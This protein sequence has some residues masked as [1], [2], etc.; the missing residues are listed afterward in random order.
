MTERSRPPVSPELPPFSLP[1]LEGAVLDTGLEILAVHDARL[2]LVHW[3]LG[4]QAGSKFEPPEL[5]GLS[6][7]TAAV[8]TQGTKSRTAREI[9]ERVAA[10][11]ASLRAWSN[12]DALLLEG[13]VLAENLGAFL[14]LACDVARNAV[15]PEEEVELR[16]QNRK[17]ELAAQRS[18]ADFLAQEKTAELVFGPHPYARQEP[19][20][21]SIERLERAA[22]AAFH[23]RHLK[24]D[25]AIA[26]LVGATP[27]LTQLLD[28]LNLRL[29]GWPPGAALAC[30]W[31][32]PP[33]PQRRITLVD[34]P[35]SVQADLRIGRLAVTRTHPDYF[36]LLVAATVLGGGASSRLFTNI[37]EK[38]GYAYDAHCAL[39]A[40][41][42]AGI[43]E[44]VTQIRE[45][46]LAEA[47]AAVLEEMRRLGREPVPEDELETARNYL[48]GTYVIRLETLHGLANQLAFTRLMDLPLRYLEEYTGRVRSVTAGQVQEVAARYL[49]PE[50]A[51]IVAVGEAERIR[52][53]LESFGEVQY[54]RA[55]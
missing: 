26:V 37:R 25:G 27:P 21:E 54:E 14:E 42:E 2:P 7:T 39:T 17:Q 40:W 52:A 23:E 47:L 43:V 12:A 16:K 6:E 35:G 31:P 51:A 4:F 34:R 28:E 46:V 19:T 44:V 18:L 13:S 15:Y 36:P 53:A 3:R 1:H 50:S 48:C 38:R 29:A 20:P 32:E 9:A 55:P 41:R 8:M 49:D 45:E 30:Q 5:R 33:A 11:G 10:L 24:P 22:L